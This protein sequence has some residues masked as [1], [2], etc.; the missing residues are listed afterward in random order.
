MLTIVF[1]STVTLLDLHASLKSKRR[2]NLMLGFKSSGIDN[3]VA[4]YVL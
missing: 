4:F 3:L 1:Q 2:K